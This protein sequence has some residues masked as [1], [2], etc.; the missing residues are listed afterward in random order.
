MNKGIIVAVA[1]FLVSTAAGVGARLTLGPHPPA[2]PAEAAAPILSAGLAGAAGTLPGHGDGN[3]P[4]MTP[5]P[6][7]AAAPGAGEGSQAPGA[8]SP[9]VTDESTPSSDREAAR[10]SGEGRN[11][12]APEMSELGRCLQRMPPRDAALLMN[13]LDDAQVISLISG[14]TLGDALRV[15][16]SLPPG[17]AADIRRELF[18]KGGR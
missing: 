11:G 6:G 15:L 9:A 8:Q 17:R 7:P 18:E 2:P 12:A 14:M 1:A 5:R 10:R 4:A 16:E 3:R 13:Y